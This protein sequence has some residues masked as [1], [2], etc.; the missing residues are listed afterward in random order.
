MTAFASALYASV[1]PHVMSQNLSCDFE[2]PPL[3]LPPP[4]AQAA[5][6]P[7][8]RAA[9]VKPRNPR[10]DMW[11]P[12]VGKS[13]VMVTALSSGIAEAGGVTD[14]RSALGVDEAITIGPMTTQPTH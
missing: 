1:T 13:L 10:R 3:P 8:A 7:T 6:T 12:L 2:P 14:V 11:L 9:P 5:V 4:A